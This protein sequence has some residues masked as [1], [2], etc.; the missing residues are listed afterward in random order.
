MFLAVVVL[1]EINRALFYED[2]NIM[3]FVNFN[4]FL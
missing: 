1:V 3:I 4:I 2:F